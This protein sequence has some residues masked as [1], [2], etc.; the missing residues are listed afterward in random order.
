VLY[1]IE[2]NRPAIE[3]LMRYAAEQKLIPRA[4][5]VNELFVPDLP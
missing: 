3:L 5:R 1:G 2:A 4:Y